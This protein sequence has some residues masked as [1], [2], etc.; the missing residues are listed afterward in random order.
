[1]LS[2]FSWKSPS[3]YSEVSA[4]FTD[5]E[6]RWSELPIWYAV[7]SSE[8]LEFMARDINQFRFEGDDSTARETELVMERILAKM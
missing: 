2:A 5:K 1:E 3:I 6:L 4:A 7:D 8:E